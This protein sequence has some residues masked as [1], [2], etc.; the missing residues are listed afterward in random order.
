MRGK[1]VVVGLVVLAFFF[2]SSQP[3]ATAASYSTST[4]QYQAFIGAKY[5]PAP[6]LGCD[7]SGLW[8]YKFGGDNRG[9]GASRSPY[10]L[11]YS[12]Y[13][14]WKTGKITTAARTGVTRVY[15]ANN[16]LVSERTGKDNSFTVKKLAGSTRDRYELRI[17][18]QGRDPYCYGGSIKASVTISISRSGGYKIISGEHSAAPNH[19]FYLSNGKRW[20]TVHRFAG[21]DFECLMAST[22]PPIKLG[23]L[24]GVY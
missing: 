17:A 23:G 15:D 6:I 19:E 12:V 18:V 7:Y 22:C 1:A 11:K 9:F 2:A 20:T 14:N 16:K 3:S 4:I 24:K 21:K 8:G 13:I 5:A 10:R